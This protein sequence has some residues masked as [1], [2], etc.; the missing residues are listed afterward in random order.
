MPSRYQPRQQYHDDRPDRRMNDFNHQRI[1]NSERYPQRMEEEAA[2]EGTYDTTYE[3][4]D[5]TASPNDQAGQKASH[6]ADQQKYDP[7]MLYCGHV[8]I[9]FPVF[10]PSRGD[11]VIPE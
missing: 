1:F 10:H 9:S 3:A 4:T 6:Q 7:G 5:Q 8:L 2:D 11:Q